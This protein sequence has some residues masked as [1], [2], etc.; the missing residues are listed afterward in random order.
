MRSRSACRIRVDNQR[1]GFVA[2]RWHAIVGKDTD[3]IRNVS[4]TVL[5]QLLLSS[6]LIAYVTDY[7]AERPPEQ[8]LRLCLLRTAAAVSRTAHANGVVAASCHLTAT[9]RAAVHTRT[10]QVRV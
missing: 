4:Q 9:T 8:L 7:A 10:E 6:C 2:L 3:K 5:T 1:F